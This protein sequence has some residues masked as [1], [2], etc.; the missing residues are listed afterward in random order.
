MAYTT[1]D[2]PTIHFN[3]KLYTGTG[4][5]NAVTGVGFQPDWVWIK[6]RSTTGNHALFD[7][8]NGVTKYVNSNTN[9]GLQ[10]SAPTVTSFDSDGFTVGSSADLNGSGNSIASWNWLAGGSASSNSNGSITSSV[11]VNTTAGFSIV[12]FSGTGSLGT[13][14]HGLG[15]VPDVLFFKRLDTTGAWASYH[16]PLGATKYMRLDSTSAQITASDEFNDTEPTST[17]FTVATD[18]G[19]NASG[20]DN[21]LVYCMTEIKGYSKFGSYTGNGDVDGTFVYTGFRPAWVMTKE[22]SGTGHWRIR[23][24]KRFDQTNPIDKV[25]YANASTT[26]T[27]EDNTDFLSNGFKLRTTGG[28]N[29][30]SGDTYIYLAFAESPF[31]NSSGIPCNAR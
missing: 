3:T 17:V 9:Y 30:G 11:S 26:E 8:I 31:V 22:S 12:R 29:N 15:A 24:N 7:V 5:S 2:D 1:I 21:M 10:T 18:G 20:T 13:V 27:D 4:S 25:L 14:G 6:N 19:V 28:E 23:D 16:K